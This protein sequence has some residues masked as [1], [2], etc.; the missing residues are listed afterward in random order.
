M[1]TSSEINY[2]TF[3]Q[4]ALWI[5]VYPLTKIYVFALEILLGNSTEIL[6]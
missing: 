2:I 6:F 1:A 5:F 4:F 3:F